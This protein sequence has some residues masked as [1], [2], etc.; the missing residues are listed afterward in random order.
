MFKTLKDFSVVGK[1][2]LVRC[3]FN[4]PVDQKGN[5][6]D[7]F[8]IQ[9]A[10][11][12]IKYLIEAKAKVILMSHLDPESTNVADP[13]FNFNGVAQILSNFLKIS[14]AKEEDCVGPSVEVSANSLE[15]GQ[16]LL[17]ENLRFHEE[18]TEGNIEFAKKLSYLGDIYVNEAFSVCHRNHASIAGVPQFLPKCAGLS[19]EKEIKA[20][21]KVMQNPERPM[22]AVAGGKKVETKSKFIDKISNIADLV[23]VSGLIKKEM[24]D[25]KIE[26]KNKEKII[27]PSGNLDALDI[28]D[29]SVKLFQEKI[30]G[31]KTILWNG[32]FGKFED[33]N[34]A[35]GT[36]AIANAI[37]ESGAFSVVGGGE[38]VEFLEK[39][40]MIVK[41]SHV[42][43][44]GGAMLSYLAGDKLPGLEALK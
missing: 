33:E 10:L 27:G 2:I 39:K 12:T 15:P 4:V 19:L 6:L 23:I 1:R 44:G 20:L 5:I 7:D 25:K 31:A 38:T 40:G 41:F 43:T 42:S 16:V 17:L 35:K 14:I 37:I 9:Q 18:E 28:N 29:E 32:P 30:M 3:D 24:E 13:K 36:L 11:P 26:F 8:R 21:D 22:V 34:Y